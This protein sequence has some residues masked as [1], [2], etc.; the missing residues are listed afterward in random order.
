MGAWSGT[1]AACGRKSLSPRGFACACRRWVWPLLYF[2]VLSPP[3][4]RKCASA[5]LSCPVGLALTIAGFALWV[6]TLP[7]S[8][9]TLSI[10]KSFDILVIN[11][12]HYTFVRELGGED[13]NYD[14]REDY[15][16]Q[17]KKA[18]QQKQADRVVS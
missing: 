13:A 3:R 17:Q 6:V 1:G 7:I 8:I 12:A 2:L 9:P 11:P 14:K 18:E 10:E 16:R 4:A 15:I 5:S